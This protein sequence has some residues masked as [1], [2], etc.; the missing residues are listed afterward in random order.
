MTYWIDFILMMIPWLLFKTISVLPLG[1]GM[2]AAIRYLRKGVRHAYIRNLFGSI[3]AGIVALLMLFG[4]L[5]GDDLSSSSTAAIIFIFVPIYAALAQGAV[6]WIIGKAETSKPISFVDRLFL[7][8]PIAILLVLMVGILK[9]SI[10]GN[11]SAIAYRAPNPSTLTR[12]YEKSLQGEAD[13]FSIPLALSENPHTPPNI[14]RQLTAHEHPAVRIHTAQH[15]ATPIDAVASLRN[16]RSSCVR[17]IVERR[18]RQEQ[19]NTVEL[20]TKPRLMPDRSF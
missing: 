12:I 1:L 17:K 15:S 16:D 18:L 19:N 7:L 13:S 20:I 4:S 3:A 11:D 2:L 10:Q 6:Y 5:F 8:I 9:N 14:L